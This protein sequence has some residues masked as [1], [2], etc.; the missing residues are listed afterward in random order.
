MSLTSL[1]PRN[2][3]QLAAYLAPVAL[4]L[5]LACGDPA[6]LA[7]PDPVSTA[8]PAPTA[9]LN[10]PVVETPPTAVA[11][12][13]TAATPALAPIAPTGP[14]LIPTLPVETERLNPASSLA[15]TPAPNTVSAPPTGVPPES[16]LFNIGA[17]G[18]Q[19]MEF[20]ETLTADHSPRESATEQELEAAQ[21][22][23]AEFESLGYETAIV[24]FTVERIESEIELSSVALATTT[25]Y[26]TLPLSRSGQGLSRGFLTPVG[27]AYPEDIPEEGLDGQ[28]A[29]I[30]RGTIPFEEKVTR[31][32][33]AGAIAAIIYNG[34]DGMFRGTLATL[35]TIPA[36]S[37]SKADGEALLDLLSQGDISAS[38]TVENRVMQSR[39]VVA[40][41]KGTMDDGRSVVIG[42]HYD[43]V[44]GVPGANDNGSG[45]ATTMTVARAI[46]GNPY[47]FTRPH[48]GAASGHHRDDQLR[49]SRHGR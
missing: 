34:T 19:A 32:A 13:P 27:L 3:R 15:P 6:E 33:E 5:A 31:V 2:L 24:P 47:P 46:A 26:R 20:L 48:G 30:Q 17:L 12:S 35:S 11:S 10:A 42:G 25:T 4:A 29:L 21:F 44:A 1:R 14:I 28:V 38:V 36:V 39:N 41:M 9:R 8:I 23:A 37:M 45:T 49:C 43:T 16:G 18:D 40:E 22:L 7:P